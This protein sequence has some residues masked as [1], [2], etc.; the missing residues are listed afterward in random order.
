MTLQS[1]RI[2]ELKRSKC[3][4]NIFDVWLPKDA[5]ELASTLFPM[6]GDYLVENLID[7]EILT[8]MFDE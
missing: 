7:Q 8:L 3:R 4:G 6:G 1:G 2:L 5:S